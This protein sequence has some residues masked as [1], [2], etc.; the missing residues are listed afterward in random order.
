MLD[1]FRPVWTKLDYFLTYW[2]IWTILDHF[3]PFWEFLDSFGLYWSNLDLFG[4]FW[5]I[6][7]LFEPFGPFSPPL[8]SKNVQNKMW[9]NI[10]L[11]EKKN[12]YIINMELWGLFLYWCYYPHCSRD[13]L[14]GVC[15]FFFF[16]KLTANTNITN[17]TKMQTLLS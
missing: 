8:P 6:L 7:D 3:W 16:T 12:I 5:I 2:T 17:T 9:H 15:V 10:C 13:S 4:P 14:S 1:N 11:K